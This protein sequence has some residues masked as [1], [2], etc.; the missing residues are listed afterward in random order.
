MLGIT[1]TKYEV[2]GTTSFKK[3]FKK[4]IRQGKDI[5]KFIEILNSL[6]SGENLDKKYKDHALIDNKH[7]KRCRECHIESD[8]L[9]VYKYNNEE[10][11]LLMVGI[12]SHSELFNK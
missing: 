1:N 5:N 10:L 3:Q 12:G 6:A 8:W 4:V 2:K 9:L 7:Y 11:I